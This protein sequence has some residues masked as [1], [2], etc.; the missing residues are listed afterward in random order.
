[1]SVWRTDVLINV[2]VLY[3]S[4]WNFDGESMWMNFHF[5]H[6]FLTGSCRVS[7]HFVRLEDDRAGNFTP[8]LSPRLRDTFS[9]ILIVMMN[10]V[11]YIYEWYS[12]TLFICPWYKRKQLNSLWLL[13][14]LYLKSIKTRWFSSPYLY[15]IVAAALEPLLLV[16]CCFLL[17]QILHTFLFMWYVVYYI[18]TRCVLSVDRTYVYLD[19]VRALIFLS[20]CSCRQC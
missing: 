10:T 20:V 16:A 8:G 15:V 14:L 12:S 17:L 7:L 4:E 6:Q 5:W 13:W 11:R 19:G 3:L 18:E 9:Y 2:P 1:M